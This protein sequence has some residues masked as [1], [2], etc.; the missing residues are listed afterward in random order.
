MIYKNCTSE[1]FFK[2][3]NNK[4][5]VFGTSNIAMAFMDD[6][7][8]Y[9]CTDKIL[10]FTDNDNELWDQTINFN[11]NEYSINSP[12]HLKYEGSNITIIIASTYVYDISCQLENYKSLANAECFFYPFMKWKPAFDMTNY[13]EKVN[14]LHNKY[15]SQQEKFNI[16]KDSHSGERCFIVGNGPSLTAKDLDLLKNEFCFAANQIF[17]AFKNTQWRPSAYLTVNVDTFL[18]YQSEINNLNCTKF[19]D[20][21]ALDYGVEIQDALYLKHGTFAGNE[22]LFSEDVSKFYYNGG[23]VTYTAIQVAAY[24]GFKE[25]YLIGVDNNFTFEKNKNGIKRKNDIQNHFYKDDISNKKADLYATV[26]VDHLTQSF[27]RAKDYADAHNI[28]ILNATRGGK[29]E[30]FNRIS[31][32]T[33]LDT[34]KR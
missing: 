3:V 18:A 12:E 21:K 28:K 29:L 19:I 10:Y 34:K 6:A 13:I 32:E 24:M 20:K 1:N 22:D 33:L 23:T 27:I 30:V 15:S 5:V 9:N 26:D 7:E 2:S 25:I 4:I 8:K 31:L 17:F 16:L 11:G 14:K